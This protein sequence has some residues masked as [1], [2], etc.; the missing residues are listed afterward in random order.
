M[1]PPLTLNAIE[2]L[3]RD[4]KSL[5]PLLRETFRFPCG[6]LGAERNSLR[7]QAIQ[8]IDDI[9]MFHQFAM[10]TH[11]QSNQ[12]IAPAFEAFNKN[13]NLMFSD[14][15]DDQG[16][17]SSARLAFRNINAAAQLRQIECIA[18]ESLVI[19]L[20]ATI[21][22]IATRCLA[23]ISTPASGKHAPYR[24][25]NIESHYKMKNII[26]TKSNVHFTIDE[27]SSK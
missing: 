6:I 22:Q 2:I 3:S 23:I 13:Y 17:I 21:E 25:G 11:M 16:K 18:N 4:D 8:R 15:G 12:I 20:W 7:L 26:L 27:L 1:K 10:F 14:M 9:V 5:K 24:W 19:N